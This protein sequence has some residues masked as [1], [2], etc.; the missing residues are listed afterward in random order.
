VRRRRRGRRVVTPD[1]YVWFVRRRRARRRT[2]WSGPPPE[3]FHG[4]EALPGETLPAPG[5][6]SLFASDGYDIAH[7]TFDWRIEDDRLS[8]FYAAMAIGAAL[9]VVALLVW[10]TVRYVLPWLVPLAVANARPLLAVA[11]ALVVLA[12]LNQLHRPWWVELQRQGLADA[13]RRVWRVQGW[14]RS[15]R[16]MG[17]LTAA[18]R[19]GRIDNR[20]AVILRTDGRR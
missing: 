5:L 3:R 20:R 17:E 12:A 8:S 10:L 7:P 9:A 14:R 15:G 13:P 18:I 11:V 19:E 1:G 16:L 6:L 2:L 4:E